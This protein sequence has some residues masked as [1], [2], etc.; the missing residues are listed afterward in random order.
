MVTLNINNKEITVSKEL[1]ILQAASLIDIH[2]PRFCFHE[3]L[4]IAGNCRMCL[5]EVAKV[6]KPVASCALPVAE[7]MQVYTNSMMVKKAREGVLELL[8]INHPLDCP[9]CDQG[10]ECDLQDQTLIFGNDRSRFYESKRAVSDKLVSPLIKTIMT[11]CIHCTRCV[12][13]LTEITG[14]YEL[15]ITGRGNNSEIGTYVKNQINSEL[16]GNVIDLCPV[17]A[18]TSKPY[19]FTARPWELKSVETIDL[20]DSLL[21]NIKMYARGPKLMRVLPRINEKLN[22]EWI[23]DKARFNFDG[24]R[25]QRLDYPLYTNKVVMNFKI[26]SSS[27]KIKLAYFKIEFLPTTWGYALTIFKENYLNFKF[28]SA[29]MNI[30]IGECSSLENLISL[31][32]FSNL[33]NLNLQPNLNLN[34]DAICPLD[35]QSSYL[36]NLNSHLN[37]NLNSCLLVGINLR[38]ENPILNSKLR[39]AVLLNNCVVGS[40]GATTNSIYN[41]VNLG[42][43]TSC[44]LKLLM[45]K[46]KFVKTLMLSTNSLLLFNSSLKLK[47]NLIYTLLTWLN[48]LIS[49]LK[50]KNNILVSILGLT[51]YLV[52]VNEINLLSNTNVNSNSNFKLNYL[53]DQFNF[54]IN[55]DNIQLNHL[56]NGDNKFFTVY[57]GSHGDRSV[58]QSNLILPSNS[59]IEELSS[60]YAL[61]GLIQVGNIVTPAPGLSRTSWKITKALSLILNFK[62]FDSSNFKSV[63]PSLNVLKPLLN[64]NLNF[65]NTNLSFKNYN[66]N[67]SISDYYINNTV[68]RS[69]KIMAATSH[70]YNAGMKNI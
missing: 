26:N 70:F 20:N 6:A 44:L 36:L 5:V 38:S 12:R 41:L 50:S 55:S 15:G 14:T 3:K 35:F 10:G 62:W 56:Y 34:F 46:H 61:N 22:G 28:S 47:A 53:P 64:L 9:I 51:P 30:I 11:R 40:I 21:S 69:S 58:S 17:G 29:N 57:Q 23:T 43:S 1:T 52:T 2:I 8:L 25:T 66:L 27:L 13:F 19:A 24:L 37:M 33:A 31:K 39:K 67:N 59:Y 45:G 32:R 54:L 18:L 49:N 68:G 63:N 48:T 65:I 7:G 60:F 4:S 42:N 16:S